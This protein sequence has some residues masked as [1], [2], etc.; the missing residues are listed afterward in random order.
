MELFDP[1]NVTGWMIVLGLAACVW[2]LLV[3]LWVRAGRGE[4]DAS[5]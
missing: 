5:D 2:A 1:L 4:N 3:W